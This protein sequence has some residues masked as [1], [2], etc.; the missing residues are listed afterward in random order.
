MKKLNK[1][2]KSY[3][4]QKKRKLRSINA[5]NSIKFRPYG[6]IDNY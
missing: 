6:R 3:E 2:S 5:W 1:K 4:L